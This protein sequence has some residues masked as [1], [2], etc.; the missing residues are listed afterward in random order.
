MSQTVIPHKNC[1][2]KLVAHRNKD[3]SEVIGLEVAL[4]LL[5]KDFKKS[6]KKE[7]DRKKRRVEYCREKLLL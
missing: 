4:L 1:A 2:Y 5:E 7:K 3:S 6:Q